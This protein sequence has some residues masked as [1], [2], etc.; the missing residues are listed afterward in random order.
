MKVLLLAVSLWTSAPVVAN[1]YQIT[2]VEK[3]A[4]FAGRMLSILQVYNKR[5]TKLYSDL[6]NMATIHDSVTYQ[7]INVSQFMRDGASYEDSKKRSY[8]SEN[9]TIEY[10]S[11]NCREERI[12]SLMATAG[13]MLPRLTPYT[14]R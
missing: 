4:H 1:T 12:V 7:D 6:Y 2:Q 5:N 13:Q 10:M 14:N 9:K 3:T 11:D 8:D